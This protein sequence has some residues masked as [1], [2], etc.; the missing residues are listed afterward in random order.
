MNFENGCWRIRVISRWHWKWF[1]KFAKRDR[2]LNKVSS[3][4]VKPKPS[5]ATKRPFS[6]KFGKNFL[7]NYLQEQEGI[8]WISSSVSSTR[9]TR[10]RIQTEYLS[11][12]MKVLPIP[13]TRS[14]TPWMWRNQLR[15][16]RFTT[17]NWHRMRRLIIYIIEIRYFWIS[18]ISSPNRNYKFRWHAK[19][20]LLRETDLLL[21][22]KIKHVPDRKEH[23]FLT[24]HFF[25]KLKKSGEL[26]QILNRFSFRKNL[27]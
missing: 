2:Q 4:F 14:F 7:W 21:K 16:F 1:D 25:L 23:L 15:G 11:Y 8:K 27:R 6:D 3:V 26:R 5:Y 19:Q 10:K 20:I 17:R 9:K 13:I 24:V 12:W 18:K 22:N